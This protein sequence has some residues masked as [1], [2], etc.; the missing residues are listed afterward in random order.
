M[1]VHDAY[2]YT[3]SGEPIF[4]EN[5]SKGVIYIVR[6]PLDIVVSSKYHYNSSLYDIIEMMSNEDYMV[7]NDS[8]CIRIQLRQKFLSWSS[9]VKSW[10]RQQNIPVLLVKY[11]DMVVST[12]SIFK[13]MVTFSGLEVSD[14]EINAAIDLVSFPNLQKQELENGFNERPSKSEL[15][16][17]KGIIGNWKE[18]LSSTQVNLIISNHSN[19]MGELGYIDDKGQLVS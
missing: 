16:F 4:P 3:E 13:E 11:E 17:R 5:I 12:F 9:H 1:K 19:V 18:E 7:C 6:N 10:V 8:N 2:T 14:E 15:F